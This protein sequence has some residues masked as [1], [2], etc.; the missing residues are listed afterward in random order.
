MSV[1]ESNIWKQKDL[2]QV[3]DLKT[4]EAKIDWTFLSPYKG[5]IQPFSEVVGDL[6]LE[7]NIEDD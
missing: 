5:T 6:G 3:K 4:L 1:K 2:S 7:I